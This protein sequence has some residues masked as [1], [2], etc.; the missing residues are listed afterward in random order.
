MLKSILA[1]SLVFFSS[2][3]LAESS[4][5][6]LNEKAAVSAKQGKFDEAERLFKQAIEVD[7]YN[8]TAV[9]NLSGVYAMNKKELQAKNLLETYLKRVPNDANLYAR[10]GDVNFSLKNLKDAILNYEKALA[11]NPKYMGLYA[12]MAPI[13]LMQNNIEEA[14][15]ALRIA[16]KE[17]PKE[18]ILYRNFSAVLLTNKKYAESIAAA[19]KALQI[20]ASSDAYITLGAAYER[21]K[22]LNNALIAYERAKDLGSKEDNLEAKI[23]E[24][25][26]IL[27]K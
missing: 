25:K 18:A 20:E 13:Y 11:V 27:K 19:K 10:L 4:S 23:Q 17:A 8:L 7:P 9:Y 12:K 5:L 14:E 1:L 24:L 21:S 22:D 26:G 6:E 15:M 3:A 16:I 2:I